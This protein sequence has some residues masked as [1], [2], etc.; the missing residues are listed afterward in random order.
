MIVCII[1]TYT[2]TTQVRQWATN[3]VQSLGQVDWDDFDNMEEVITWMVTVIVF[4]QFDDPVES[5]GKYLNRLAHTVYIKATSG[6]TGG[7]KFF[8]SRLCH[9]WCWP[10]PDH[11]LNQCWLCD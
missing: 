1:Y 11:F 9:E 7:P 3:V 4:D 10:R 8:L 6:T 5:S 2:Y